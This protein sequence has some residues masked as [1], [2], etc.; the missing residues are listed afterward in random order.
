MD[1]RRLISEVVHGDDD[2]LRKLLEA[3]YREIRRVA[4]QRLRQH[5]PD[6]TFHTTVLANELVSSVLANALEG[7]CPKWDG[8]EHF[9]NWMARAMRYLLVNHARAKRAQK[10]GGEHT[11]RPID[12]CVGV[13]GPDQLDVLALDE[14]L[15][16]LAEANRSQARIVELR[17]FAGLTIPETAEALG[18]G[19][20]E[21]NYKWKCAR[22][23]LERRLKNSGPAALTGGE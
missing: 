17:F 15:T 18:I 5:G 6:L 1:W 19:V 4:H 22:A 10:R 3:S 23:W 11:R 13:T 12:E 20:G 9:F 21:V 16:E 7:K 2:A 8:P 14:V